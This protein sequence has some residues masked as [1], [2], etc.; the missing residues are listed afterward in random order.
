[1][2]E[3]LPGSHVGEVDLHEGTSDPGEGIPERHGGMGKPPSVHEKA[4][5][6]ARC[7]FDEIQK[8]AFV[9]GLEHLELYVEFGGQGPESPVDVAER[10]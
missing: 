6:A 10:P 4:L 7:L 2:T 5:D 9:I 8:L 3:G 1:M